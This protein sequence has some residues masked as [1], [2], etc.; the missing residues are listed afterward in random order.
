[1]ISAELAAALMPPLKLTASAGLFSAELRRIDRATATSA[2]TRPSATPAV[3]Q[4]PVETIVAALSSGPKATSE[5]MDA[6]G[7]TRSTLGNRLRELES[8]RLIEPTAAR[9]SPHVKWRRTTA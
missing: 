7:L 4:K 1:M 2:E 9:R 5:L 8:R 3:A 6:T